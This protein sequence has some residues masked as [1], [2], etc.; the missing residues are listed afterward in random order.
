MLPTVH[1]A[2]ANMTGTTIVHHLMQ[3]MTGEKY[4]YQRMQAFESNLLL[5]GAIV[6]KEKPSGNDE[7]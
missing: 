4:P 5:N 1:K 7:V 6:R 3:P 2:P